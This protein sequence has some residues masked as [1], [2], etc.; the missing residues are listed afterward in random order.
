MRASASRAARL[1]MHASLH[2]AGAAAIH[3]AIADHGIEGRMRPHVERAGRDDIDMALQDQGTACLAA[4]AMDANNDRRR[5]MLG[6]KRTAAGMSEN[7]ATIHGEDIDCQSSR[8]HLA[9]HQVLR[10]VLIAARRGAAH[11]IGGQGEAGHRSPASTELLDALL[12][13]LLVHDPCPCNFQI[14]ASLALADLS[15]KPPFHLERRAPAAHG[16]AV[17]Y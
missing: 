4:R 8:P 3:P 1:E 14:R 9:R 6:R 11:Q 2:V 7:L 17:I 16:A 13:L 10:G 12:E 5:G 15:R